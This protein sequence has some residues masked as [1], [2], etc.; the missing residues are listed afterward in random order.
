MYPKAGNIIRIGGINTGNT[1]VEALTG[2]WLHGGRERRRDHSAGRGR[3]LGHVG[4]HGGVGL[5]G[6]DAERGEAGG[7][8]E[9]SAGGA[10]HR[11]LSPGVREESCG[12]AG[13]V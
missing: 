13:S 8:P 5:R 1:A 7:G 9:Q 3:R 4:R 11:V 6:R 12:R 10:R 2:F